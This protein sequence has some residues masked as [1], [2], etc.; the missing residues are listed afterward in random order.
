MNKRKWI[1]TIL[2]LTTSLL[3]AQAHAGNWWEKIVDTVKTFDSSSESESS[4]VNELGSEL[5]NGDISSAFKQALRIG[6]ENVVNQLGENDGFNTDSLIHI[7]LPDDLKNV[8]KVLE[9]VGLSYIAD[10][11]EL[12]LNRAAEAATPKAK[13][14]FMDSIQKMTFEDVKKIYEGPEDSA[15]RYFQGKMTP[16]L[17]KEMEPIVNKSVSEVGAIQAYD[18]LLGEYKDL[19]FVP[20]VKADLTK[21]VI[22]KGMDGIFYYLAKEEAAIRKDPVKQTTDLLRRV[23][24]SK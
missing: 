7:P 6:S 9:K 23:F 14:L 18:K 19:P 4:V 17:A 21:H 15:T 22:E 13:K 8:K 24:G 10:D 20:D 1:A 12:K 3:T 16:A 11:L 5:S 2:F